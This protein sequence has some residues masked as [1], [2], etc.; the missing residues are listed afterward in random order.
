MLT[1]RGGFIWNNNMLVYVKGGGA[2][3]KTKY[4]FAEF[5]QP[6]L[7]ADVDRS[8]WTI[9]GGVEYM[10]LPNWSLAVEYNRVN[11]DKETFRLASGQVMT[12]DQKIDIMTARVNY[13]LPVKFL[14]F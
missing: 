12:A 14:P 6:T 4:S 5:G 8:G 9:G 7:Y 10:F 13:H 3:T 1:G 2:W 11:F